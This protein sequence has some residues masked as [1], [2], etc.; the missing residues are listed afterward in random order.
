[1]AGFSKLLYSRA[2]SPDFPLA[3]P[4]KSQNSLF[5]LPEEILDEDTKAGIEL[6]AEL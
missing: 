5:E 4:S 3:I 2:F 1:M 6:V